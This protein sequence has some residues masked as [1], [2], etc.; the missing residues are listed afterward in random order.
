MFEQRRF[1]YGGQD[2]N[3]GLENSVVL[4]EAE[5]IFK[6]SLV[7]I[8]EA[9]DEAGAD[10]QSSVLNADELGIKRVANRILQFPRLFQ[11]SNSWGLY[12]DEYGAKVRLVEQLEEFR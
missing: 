4:D 2:P 9:D 10:I 8:V 3:H 12:T 5:L 7:I 1:R 11:R 6:N